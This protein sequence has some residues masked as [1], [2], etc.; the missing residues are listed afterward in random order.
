MIH[1]ISLI[2]PQIILFLYLL[3]F[4]T[5]WMYAW[6]I[7]IILLAMVNYSLS[8]KLRSSKL[9]SLEINITKQEQSSIGIAHGM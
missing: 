5:L 4:I 2:I 8:K 9:K 1:A 7:E 6:D 3:I